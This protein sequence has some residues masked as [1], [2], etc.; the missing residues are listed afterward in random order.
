M[1]ILQGANGTGKSTL[2]EA[3][4]GVLRVDAG[5]VELGGQEVTDWPLHRRAEAGLGYLPQGACLVPG[6]D[7]W[8]NVA[9][10]G[11]S[12]SDMEEMLAA[13]SLTPLARRKVGELS[14]GE[15]RRVELARCMVRPAKILLLD[16]PLWGLDTVQADAVWR[17]LSER[18]AQGVAVLIADPRAEWNVK[19]ACS[20]VE[21]RGGQL[22]RM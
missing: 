5:V 9:L 4:A 18:V 3:L 6:L 13:L 20:R 21:V 8:S 2:L 16:E 10:S 7:V 14:G 17:G 12:T 11:A 22:K 19:I 15:R 1:V